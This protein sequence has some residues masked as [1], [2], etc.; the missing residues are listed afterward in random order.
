MRF[1]LVA[2]LL[3]AGVVPGFACSKAANGDYLIATK[4]P[5]LPVLMHGGTFSLCS[6]VVNAEGTYAGQVMDCGHGALPLRNPDG[7]GVLWGTQ[8]F[9]HTDKCP[10]VPQP[11][12][13]KLPG[14]DL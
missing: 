7:G 1:L 2:L 12:L 8:L 4:D 5:T 6:S 11:F 13:D 3:L 14:F 9:I 10:T